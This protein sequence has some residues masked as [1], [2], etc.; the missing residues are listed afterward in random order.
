MG[1]IRSLVANHITFL[2]LLR[3]SEI[4]R[5]P[6]GNQGSGKKIQVVEKK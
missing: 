5:Q 2:D 6:V 3:N 4:K 1:N